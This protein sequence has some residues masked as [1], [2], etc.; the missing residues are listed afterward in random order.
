MK[1]LML[2]AVILSMAGLSYADEAQIKTKLSPFGVTNMEITDAPIAGLKT[3]VSDQGI[4]YATDDGKYFLQGSLVEIT[5]NG[6]KDLTNQP[7]MSKLNAFEKD[8]IVYP[9]KDEKYVVTVFTDITCPYCLQLHKNMQ[10]YNDLGITVRYLA[11]PRAGTSSAT[12]RQME[13]IWQSSNPKEAFDQAEKGNIPKTE[14]PV[15]IVKK[16]YDLGVQFGIGGTPAII[17]E[18][19]FVLPGY[20]EPAR[21]LQ[22]LEQN[23]N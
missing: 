16:Q 8:M 6:P 11:F 19:G 22:A 14:T 12:A 21:L 18:N 2:S 3:V 7:L 9:A 13:T 23:G 20:V 10:K 4:F 15:D 17:F 5:P 1:K